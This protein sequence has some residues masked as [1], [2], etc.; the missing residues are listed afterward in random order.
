MCL[1]CKKYNYRNARRDIV[2]YKV[3]DKIVGDYDNVHYTTPYQFM[4]VEDDI[5]EGKRLFE[6]EGKCKIMRN[7][8]L[9][10]KLL[11]GNGYIHTF[12][13]LKDARMYVEFFTGRCI[14]ECIIPK[15]VGYL[16]GKN[17]LILSEDSYASKSIRFIREI[18]Q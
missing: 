17:G 5:I 7:E 4:R 8:D 12:K 6:V 14:F 16:S 10:D 15:G 13:N 2:C 18:V 1:V 11:I 9:P 3:M